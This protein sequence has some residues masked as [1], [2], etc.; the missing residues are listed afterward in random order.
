M[1][2]VGGGGGDGDG[3]GAGKDGGHGG[4]DMSP[5]HGATQQTGGESYHRD[6]AIPVGPAHVLILL[7]VPQ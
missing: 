1:G 3:A 5:C 4:V 6:N 7:K 2:V